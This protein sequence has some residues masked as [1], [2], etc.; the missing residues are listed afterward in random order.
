MQ[1]ANP[2]S[3]LA[4]KIR[5]HE[6]RDYK[7]KAKDLLSDDQHCSQCGTFEYLYD[8]YASLE[9]TGRVHYDPV[10]EARLGKARASWGPIF[11]KRN[12]FVATRGIELT[13]RREPSATHRLRGASGA[14][15][16]GSL[17]S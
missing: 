16:A 1:I 17:M 15:G 4:Q 11:T 6:Q 7:D 14:E 5:I 10:R 13:R 8:D 9:A 12:I 3:F 2:A